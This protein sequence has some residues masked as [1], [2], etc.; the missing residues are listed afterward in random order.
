M[1]TTDSHTTAQLLNDI[2]DG[3]FGARDRL[4]ARIEPLLRNFA[5]G[6]VPKLLRHQQDTADV[7][8]V[9]WLKV[10]EKLPN[11]Q[12]QERGAFF[13]YLRQVLVNAL[14]DALRAQARAPNIA[15][16]VGT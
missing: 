16:E 6:R 14:R 11:I 8:Q 9:T 2:R 5:H 15:P 7:M 12:V 3:D 4:I 13:A 1:S 10:L